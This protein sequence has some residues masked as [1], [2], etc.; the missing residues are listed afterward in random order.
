MFFAYK[1][2]CSFHFTFW[3]GTG[4]E[5]ANKWNC[6]S[7]LSWAKP[8][9]TSRHFITDTR[10]SI[11]HCFSFGGISQCTLWLTLRFQ[12]RG[13][14]RITFIPTSP[15]SQLI[16]SKTRRVSWN[17]LRMSFLFPPSHP[18]VQKMIRHPSQRMR[19]R[20]T[21]S[22]NGYWFPH[23]RILTTSEVQRA[24]GSWRNGFCRRKD[25]N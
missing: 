7:T 25:K 9:G 17:F 22:T 14:L 12:A 1:Y 16:I 20:W 11:A 24:V 19:R 4:K 6:H 15:I 18:P 21:K 8:T 3:S 2:I 10:N 5:G 23:K 13:P